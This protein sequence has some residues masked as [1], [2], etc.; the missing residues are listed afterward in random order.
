[1]PDYLDSHWPR[2]AQSWR[3]MTASS[4]LLVA[5]IAAPILT[6]GC[7]ANPADSQIRT[8]IQAL[9]IQR[10]QALVKADMAVL[11]KIHAAD[12]QLITPDG[13]TESRS[14]FLSDVA[15]GNLDYRT[16]KPISPIKI[17]LLGDAAAVRYES[18]IVIIVAD[19]GRI[20]NDNWHTDLYQRRSGHWQLV[21]SQATPVGGLPVPTQP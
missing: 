14:Q 6:A 10:D 18:H 19:L 5:V 8:Q 4:V 12:Y 1:M 17:R 16:F 2:H 3:Q 11:K 7:S 15:Q 13:S 20:T 9:V 21:W